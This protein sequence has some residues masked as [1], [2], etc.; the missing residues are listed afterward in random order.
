MNDIYEWET[1]SVHAFLLKIDKNL[2]VVILIYPFH[3]YML[4][5][6]VYKHNKIDPISFKRNGSAQDRDQ[7]Y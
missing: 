5:F 7:T 6:V 3:I 4:P 1:K 2:V